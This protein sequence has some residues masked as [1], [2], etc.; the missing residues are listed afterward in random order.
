M[1]TEKSDAI[2]FLEEMSGGPLTLADLLL[3]IREGEGWTQAEMGEKLSVSKSHVSDIE[4]GREQVG[5]ARASRWATVLGYSEEQ[6]IRLA[7][8]AELDEANL[9]FRVHHLEA[10][11]PARIAEGE[12]TDRRPRVQSAGR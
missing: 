10:S 4:N 11:G 6:F 5:V 7:L 12:V 3:S 9:A 1:T 2:R 8:Q